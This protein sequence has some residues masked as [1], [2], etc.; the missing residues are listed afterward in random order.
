MKENVEDVPKIPGSAVWVHGGSFAE[1]E[2]IE[3]GAGS[4]SRAVDG[5][6]F[7]QAQVN[8]YCLI[9]ENSSKYKTEQQCRA[10]ERLCPALRISA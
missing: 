5:F 3:K 2:N 7:G 1:F 6:G 10:W 4:R 8:S 9:H